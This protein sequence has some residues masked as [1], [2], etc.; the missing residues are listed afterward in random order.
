MINS[1]ACEGGWTMQIGAQL[2][3]VRE[4]CQTLE[5]FAQ[6]LE[7]IA[8][9]GYKTVQVFNTNTLSY[10]HHILYFLYHGDMVVC[11]IHYSYDR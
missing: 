1:E 6:T 8:E 10:Q 9:I 7:R 2:Y 4:S 11:Y 5:S 3:T